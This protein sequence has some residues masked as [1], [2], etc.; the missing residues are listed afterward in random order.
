M[1]VIMEKGANIIAKTKANRNETTKQSKTTYRQVKADVF[2]L[3]L[4]LLE[5]G[6][7]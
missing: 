3:C 6:V 2:L 5:D 7:D 4:P 1:D